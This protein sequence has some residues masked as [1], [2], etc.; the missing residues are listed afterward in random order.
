MKISVTG[1]LLTVLPCCVQGRGFA[2]G[3]ADVALFANCAGLDGE[4]VEGD[5][6]FEIDDRRQLRGGRRRLK[7]SKGGKGLGAGFYTVFTSCDLVGADDVKYTIVD[8][9]LNYEDVEYA[10]DAYDNA[11]GIEVPYEERIERTF[12][13]RVFLEEVEH[14]TVVATGTKV[15]RISIREPDGGDKFLERI[16]QISIE[17]DQDNDCTVLKSA[18]EN[19]LYVSEGGGSRD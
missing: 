13:D 3:K 14:G 1:V 9:V 16:D 17:W 19:F 10:V 8:G 7:S 5:C 6:D 15:T 11:Q 4:A 18:S 12:H 2:D